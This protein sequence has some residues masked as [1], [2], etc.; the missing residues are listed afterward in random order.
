MRS[1]ALILLCLS[2][3]WRAD[4][5]PPSR[6]ACPALGP[7][8]S[9]AQQALC[10]MQSHERGEALCT[11]E[12]SREERAA[13][14]DGSTSESD[15]GTS[16]GTR[17]GAPVESAGSDRCISN[18][19]AWCA[20]AVLDEALLADACSRAR[21]RAGLVEEEGGISIP[22]LILTSF[23]AAGI[24]TG[25]ILFVMA[26]SQSADLAEA[27]PGTEWTDEMQDD[28]DHVT[29]LRVGGGVVMQAGAILIG[30]GVVLLLGN[31]LDG[32]EAE[33]SRLEMSPHR[34]GASLRWRF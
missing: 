14:P 11:D 8:A 33:S 18:A 24:I 3:A 6:E 5:D 30:V 29:T 19:V 10:W 32:D 22:G 31:A 15:D 34:R 16:D 28:Y 9:A 17:R 21:T 26:A 4:A 20:E 13:A 1:P 7:D 12:A 27:E 25:G 2:P 23:G